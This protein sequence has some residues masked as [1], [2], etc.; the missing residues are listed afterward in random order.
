MYTLLNVL[1]YN[2]DVFY[3]EIPML[4]YDNYEVFKHPN[5][6]G[7]AISRQYNGEG[8]LEFIDLVITQETFNSLSKTSSNQPIRY[9]LY[10]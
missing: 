8:F 6:T 4:D 1:D 7:F 10:A 3:T 2:N 5:Y 9:K